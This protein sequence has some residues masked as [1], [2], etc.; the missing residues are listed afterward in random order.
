MK[1]KP[2]TL[3]IATILGGFLF[4]YLFW[5]EKL[6]LNLCIYS[7]FI[8]VITI[9]NRTVIK[10][11]KM[12]LT[13][14]AHLLAA[15]LVLVNNSDLSIITWYISL[16]VFIGFA[17][18]PLIRGVLTA[19]LACWL[20][21]IV[22]PFTLIKKLIAVKIGNF[23]LKPI[24]KLATYI[25][26][27]AFFIFVFSAIYS[28]AN[29]VFNNWFTTIISEIANS[30]QK[31]LN[32]F[33][34]DVDRIFFIAIGILFTGG[35]LLTFSNN[36]IENKELQF[37]EQKIRIRSRFKSTWF[38]L[39]HTFTGNLLT[40]KT[41]LKTENTI[42]VIS[43]GALN[44]LLLTLNCIDVTT[45]WFGYIPSGNYSA[46]LHEGANALIFSIFMAMAVILYFFRGNLN[47]YPKNQ[48][49]KLLVYCWIVQNVILI[50]SVILRDYYYI[51]FNGL[52]YKRIGVLVFIL[53]CTIGL[54]T[55]YTKIAKQRTVFYLFKIN[56]F[57]AYILLI[58]FSVINWDMFITK[59]NFSKRDTI[60]FDANYLLSLS[61]KT[62]VYLDNHR[63]ELLAPANNSLSKGNAIALNPN[64]LIQQKLDNKIKNFKSKTS[65]TT[66]LSW[67]YQDWKTKRHFEY[68]RID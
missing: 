65:K 68:K 33:V 35:L 23:T 64:S 54:F 29:P 9:F 66:W 51:A 38:N 63:N 49:L 4:N 30:I 20:Q 40:K 61:D 12:E 22:V 46:N 27:P 37:N 31:F 7:I 60:V 25:I 5:M 42:A 6:A 67:N 62:L 18:Y 26:I 3:L 28:A 43:F 2:D 56:G 36:I 44:L 24:F 52:T 17:H 57:V 34:T 50:I 47:F 19:I 53:L 32:F 1:T 48:T 58:A 21:M 14:A 13:M 59:Y 39:A 8:V 45:L 41:A 10:S 55:V 15:I 16:F 11:E